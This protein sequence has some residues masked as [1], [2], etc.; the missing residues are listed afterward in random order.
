MA[1]RGRAKGHAPKN[2][3]GRGHE[4]A[5]L[6]KPKRRKVVSALTRTFAVGDQPKVPPRI[7]KHEQEEQSARDNSNPARCSQPLRLQA[8]ASPGQPQTLTRTWNARDGGE[9]SCFTSD[10]NAS[11]W[12]AHRGISQTAATENHT[13]QWMQPAMALPRAPCGLMGRLNM[14][15]ARPCKRADRQFHPRGVKMHHGSRQ[16]DP[17]RVPSTLPYLFLLSFVLSFVAFPS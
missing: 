10:S 17:F 3:E 5:V 14:R 8:A 6:H 2:D 1:L 7:R 15:S 9:V 11:T 13:R 16:A 4:Y 12:R